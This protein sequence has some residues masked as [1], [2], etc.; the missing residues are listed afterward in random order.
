MARRILIL[1]AG[2]KKIILF[3]PFHLV[4]CSACY[5]DLLLKI[6]LRLITQK[7]TSAEVLGMIHELIIMALKVHLFIVTDHEQPCSEITTLASRQ[8][9][10]ISSWQCLLCT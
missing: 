1:W 8:D 9:S 3:Q 2:A 5:T 4:I 6:I 7:P 10:E